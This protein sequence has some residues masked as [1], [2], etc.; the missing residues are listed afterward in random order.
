MAQLSMSSYHSVYVGYMRALPSSFQSDL[1]K[2]HTRGS[3]SP[4]KRL[5]EKLKEQ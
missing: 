1:Q 4:Y 3:H 2:N 5:Y